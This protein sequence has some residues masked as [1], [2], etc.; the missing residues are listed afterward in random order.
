MGVKDGNVLLVLF[1]HHATKTNEAVEV[2]LHAFLTL[3]LE[4]SVHL[5]S[6]SGRFITGK[7]NPASK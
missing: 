7:T 6:R 2:K 3:S 5:N 1:K 4:D